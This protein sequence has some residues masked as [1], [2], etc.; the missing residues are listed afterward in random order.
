MSEGLADAERIASWRLMVEDFQYELR[1]R[2][3]MCR[4]IRIA[5]IVEQGPDLDVITRMPSHCAIVSIGNSLL[6]PRRE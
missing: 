5:T 2:H 3:A 6:L 1:D 4:E